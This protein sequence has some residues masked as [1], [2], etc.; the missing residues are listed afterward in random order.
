ML[1]NALLVNQSETFKGEQNEMHP[2]LSLGHEV[3]QAAI[4]PNLFR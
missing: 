2:C 1:I 3:K 4:L